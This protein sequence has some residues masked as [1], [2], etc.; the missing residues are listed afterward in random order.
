MLPTDGT[1]VT[2]GA[3]GRTLSTE[4]TY[5]EIDP[6][7]GGNKLYNRLFF[8]VQVSSGG[9]RRFSASPITTSHD[10]FWEL[11]GTSPGGRNATTSGTEAANF[12][13]TAGQRLAFAVGS[14]ATDGNPT[15]VTPF[16]ARFGSPAQVAKPRPAPEAR[17]AAPVSNG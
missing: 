1:P 9:T 4:A 2:I 14:F 13:A 16:T 6:S 11:G 10:L 7:F 5:G 3:N 12:S 15:G 17:V 8:R